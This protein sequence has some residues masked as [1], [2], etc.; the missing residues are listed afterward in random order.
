[1]TSPF[2]DLFREAAPQKPKASRPFADVFPDTGEAQAARLETLSRNPI[3]PPEEMAEAARLARSMQMPTDVVARNLSDMRPLAVKNG[4]DWRKYITEAP[5]TA[6]WLENPVNNS[7]AAYDAE[8]L[9]TIERMAQSRF[10]RPADVAPQVPPTSELLRAEWKRGQ[11]QVERGYLGSLSAAKRQRPEVQA[12]VREIDEELSQALP[13]AEGFQ[14]FVR[15]TTRIAPGMVA[16]M[17]ETAAT[18][19]VGAIVGGII[20]AM[21]GPAA[22]V[23]IPAFT[24]IGATLGGT[25]G[26]V[27]ETSR[28]IGGNLTLDLESKGVSPEAATIA[29]LTAGYLGGAV[30][31]ANIGLVA[32]PFLKMLPLG[33]K[34]EIAKLVASG[35]KKAL[36]RPTTRAALTNAGKYYV[37]VLG[38]ETAEEIVQQG[39]DLSVEAVTGRITGAP[40]IEVTGERVRNELIETGIETL[41]SM[42]LLPIPGTAL[43]GVDGMAQVQTATARRNALEQAV[44]QA[45]KSQTR[46]RDPEAFREVVRDQTDGQAVYLDAER[47]TILLQENNVTPEEF[48]QLAGLTMQDWT[49]AVEQTGSEL[50]I[51]VDALLANM[52]ELPIAQAMLPDLKFEVGGMSARQAEAMQ[53]DM[54]AFRQQVAQEAEAI[55]DVDES[56]PSWRIV[57]DIRQKLEATGTVTPEQA[58]IQ[59]QAAAQPYRIW[60]KAIASQNPESPM[61]DPWNIYSRG[62]G[63]TVLGGERAEVL[64]DAEMAVARAKR[65]GR[66]IEEVEALRER[67]TKLADER[68]AIR[69]VLEEADQT[70][71]VRD[72]E[73]R[74]RKSLRF[75]STDAL[76]QEYIRLRDITQQATMELDQIEMAVETTTAGNVATAEEMVGVLEEAGVAEQV[77]GMA[78]AE[79]W[80]GKMAA[81]DRYVRGLRSQARKVERSVPR[82]GAELE[83]RGVANPDQYATE[84]GLT[85][86][87]VIPMG[88]L[89]FQTA[90]IR[91]GRETLKKYGLDPD[92]RY[93]NR[94][95]AQALEA[96][97]REKYGVIEADDRSPEAMR[98]IARWMVEEVEFEMRTPEQS[99]I[100]W[101]SGKYQAGLDVLGEEFPELLNG[102]ALPNGETLS[103]QGGR[104][105]LTALV[106]ITSDGADVADNMVMAV[107]VYRNFRETGQFELQRGH[108]R[109]ASLISNLQDIARLYGEL[110]ADGMRSFLLETRTVSELKKIAKDRGIKFETAYQVTMEMP[111]AV[112]VFGEKLGAFYANLMGQANYLTMDRW[113]SRTFNR[114]RGLLLPE[115]TDQGLARFRDLLEA[116]IRE[117][118]KATGQKQPPVD[119][120]QVINGIVKYRNDYFEKGFKNGTEIEKAANT[121]YKAIFDE[122]NDIP[123][124][125]TDRTFMI[126]T[127]R[128]ARK[129]LAGRGVD[130]TA[131]DLQA[132]LWYYE[133]KLYGQLTG[134]KRRSTEGRSYADAAANAL[135]VTAG[136][137][138]DREAAG[139]VPVGRGAEER[140]AGE[141]SVYGDESSAVDAG[142]APFGEILAQL[143]STEM[144]LQSA[145]HGNPYQFE[146]VQ[147]E[148]LLGDGAEPPQ[149]SRNVSAATAI[150]GEGRFSVVTGLE[151][152]L[153]R[154]FFG[155]T[156]N[157]PKEVASG[158]SAL[159]RG[160]DERLDIL[161]TDANG[162]P[163]AIIGGQK[164]GIDYALSPINSIVYDVV[165]VPGAAN[166]WFVHNHPSGKSDLSPADKAFSNNLI[167]ALKGSGIKPMGIMAVGLQSDGSVRFQHQ[168]PTGGI[169]KGK[170]TPT[171]EKVPV[172]F[173]ERQIEERRPVL[174]ETLLGVQ[175][176][177]D[178]VNRIAPEK[179]GL[180]MLNAQM[181]SV[182]FVE[183]TEK[184]AEK[185]RDTPAMRRIQEGAALV[186]ALRF[187]V[188]ARRWF[189]RAQENVQKFLNSLDP[190]GAAVVDVVDPGTGL[191]LASNRNMLASSQSMFLQD[192]GRGRPNAYYLRTD[193]V[194]GLMKGTNL[195]SFL[196]EM[197]H[198]YLAT[199]EMV[200][201]NPDA[202]AW[203]VQDFETAMAQLGVAGADRVPFVQYLRTGRGRT[204]AET[205][206]FVAAE[207]RWARSFESYLETGNAPSRG[208]Q[209][210]FASFR[211][212]LGQVYRRAKAL[213][214]PV[215][216]ELRG[217][218]DRMLATDEEIADYRSS[219]EARPLFTEKP[220]SMTDLQWDEYIKGFRTRDAIIDGELVK[221]VLA[222][223]RAAVD[224]DW[225]NRRQVA[226]EAI[227]GDLEADPTVQAVAFLRDGVDG[228]SMKL[229]RALLNSIAPDLWK[230]L[231]KGTT[232]ADGVMTADAVALRFGFAD[233]ATLIAS[234][235]RYEEID[236]I[237]ARRLAEVFRREYGDLLGD[238][239]AMADAVSAVTHMAEADESVVRE[240][241]ALGRQLGIRVV[242]KPVLVQ[243]ARDMLARMR[244]AD[245]QPYKYELAEAKEARLAEQALR[246][247]K[248]E[249]AAFHKR[250]Q[251]LNR[252]LVRESRQAVAQAEKVR[253]F[254]VRMSND[255][256]QAT[257]GKAGA[258]FADAM[259]AI[260]TDYEFARVPR[261]QISRREAIDAYVADVTEKGGVPMLSPEIIAD[262]RQVNY[263]AL[264][265]AQL[266]GVDEAMRQIW[267]HAKTID[268]IAKEG[269]KVS[270]AQAEEAIVQSLGANRPQVEM[271]IDGYPLSLSW[272]R[273]R[274]RSIDAWHVAPTFLFR[275]L[276]GDA[277][278]ETW[279]TFFAPMKDAEDAEL[280]MLKEASE[281]VKQIDKMVDLPTLLLDR[282][283]RYD[284]VRTPMTRRRLYALASNW[285]NE[286]SRMAVLEAKTA[287]GYP[288]FGSAASIERMFAEALTAKD[289]EYI[290][291]RWDFVNEYW[292]QIA[293]MERRVS[294]IT[295][296]KIEAAPFMIATADGR[297]VSV[298]GG[299]YPL[300]YDRN[301]GRGTGVERGQVDVGETALGSIQLTAGARAQTRHGWTNER[302]GSA[303]KP[304]DLSMGVWNQH[305]LSVIHDLTHREAVRDVYALLTRPKVRE[306]FVRAAG[307]PYYDA[308][309]AWLIRVANPNAMIGDVSYLEKLSAS[310]RVGTTTV[311]LGLK[312]STGIAQTLGYLQS[313]EAIGPKW[314]AIG[315]SETMSKRSKA[316]EFVMA[317]SPMMAN[318]RFSF[319]RDLADYARSRFGKM[320]NL[321]AFSFWFIGMMDG[322]V[323][324]PTWIG[325]YRKAM[326]S[327]GNDH[328]AAVRVA[329]DTVESTQGAGSA[330]DLAQVQGGP[331]FRKLLTMHYT[332]FSRMYGQFRR[333]VTNV[334]VGKY[335]LPR[336]A[337]AM[338]LLWFGQVVLSELMAA[339]R[340][341][342]DE[343]TMEQWLWS[344]ASFP[345]SL[346]VGLRDV[347]R[348]VGPEPWDYK[349]TP[350]EAAFESGIKAVNAVYR[351]T[352]GDLF[353][354][355]D[356]ELTES[357][358]KALIEA[359]GYWFR[360][361]T[362]AVWQYGD[363]MMDWMQGEVSPE[364]PGEAAAGL[365]LNR[366]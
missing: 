354:G 260:L 32:K 210:A 168:R 4:P 283:V 326:A 35:T 175:D 24:A 133:K 221:R 71:D 194:I 277:Y 37:S 287:D 30:E 273:Q 350:A 134:T 357:E 172:P 36:A 232:S 74:L 6:R 307:L 329:D 289:W 328:D 181:Q 108:N 131:A 40:G 216:A 15:G 129:L 12:R 258:S 290:Q 152:T 149:V 178:I 275:W 170:A 125:A 145:F 136:G 123:F 150:F 291:A 14:A 86:A 89:P 105:L 158:M 276:D 346:V 364:G 343:E 223:R 212:W 109:E 266:T 218:F 73:G 61:A 75:V 227:R 20:G 297:T 236:A 360:L 177:V 201:T 7:L 231:P 339:G 327:N 315:M 238:S 169:S 179:S 262:A 154:P 70:L 126:D 110:G 19:G 204:D 365:L 83:A 92:K 78:N 359:P 95:V 48:V 50:A 46:Q 358:A 240:L 176:V 250:R 99:G 144:L 241:K 45:R 313:V 362:K 309:K 332:A 306:A 251:L 141:P 319:N 101:Y 135:V 193:R 184:E 242:D 355:G 200:A 323:S 56:D 351:E 148:Q 344:L 90:T 300:A 60:A 76:V 248:P 79:T 335:G 196:H 58:A 243:V 311:N 295:P 337:A 47:A 102:G 49:Q 189:P 138:V 5:K 192:Q 113:W 33:A 65:Q 159:A 302:V 139:G 366:R 17:K 107:G 263:R 280:K 261:K 308:V 132:T 84:R 209:R 353:Y 124:N 165:R 361:P 303:G 69:A 229:N 321:D 31:V 25:Y 320:T 111:M 363:Y 143:D 288:Q 284:G 233:E 183:L 68:V 62:K 103:R 347:I 119:D 257:L 130:M 317:S 271:D 224:E 63:L 146:E 205:K 217:V 352:L 265:L 8:L 259:N 220:E 215:S 331:E 338:T 57:D 29:G 106:A 296:E 167:N 292:P 330:K 187:V 161:V 77:Q 160:A 147:R 26:S 180:L 239:T 10:S 186:N 341:D 173:Y 298:R 278:G 267:H 197:S 310:A 67:L 318:R 281:R 22:P 190:D 206:A 304:I 225:A 16:G 207:E 151:E 269:R 299:Y 286:S 268:T 128:E 195:S 41:I 191:S 88:E 112:I 115:P 255:P 244:V 94:E 349:L 272:A 44:E 11:L 120:A 140:V 155:Q 185:L 213:L 294:G 245:I 18:A 253:Q 198:E 91:E 93:N 279:N 345:A 324:V 333:A 121:L 13:E 54:E 235:Q 157:T 96:R 85:E 59:A 42:A 52:A 228:Q 285:G 81:Y 2:S 340:G 237:V 80:A 214:I 305:I 23:A 182:G 72:E 254:A 34:T 38:T 226:E 334:H 301:L 249:R 274:A 97:Q 282:P 156:A 104:D 211:V 137:R 312:F 322:M 188:V 174:T 293:E 252:I 39:I 222:E 27:Q 264:T 316:V 230:S 114:Y 43:V 21:T 171:T 53:R 28:Q 117:F 163:L 336:F 98:R 162:T 64:F 127:V 202:P 356:R 153:R 219:V 66:T 256:A 208:L 100:G 51:P 325:A 270:L 314:M 166:A 348:A 116:D 199:L 234:L 82:L 55:G 342:E 9:G 247:G 203:L 87:G 3:A 122:L 246:G 1:M 164:G 118:E 142:S